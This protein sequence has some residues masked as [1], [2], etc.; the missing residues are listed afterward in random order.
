MR[1]DEKSQMYSLVE[2]TYVSF[3]THEPRV[4]K[5]APM[6]QSLLDQWPADQVLLVIAEDLELPTFIE[7]SGIRIVRS[8]DYGAF[9]KHGPLYMDLGIN[10][11]IVVDDDAVF[12]RGWFENLLFW[13]DRLP[14]HVVCG[15]GRIWKPAAVLHYPNS[16]TVFAG[17]ISEPVLC[18]IYNG[19][20]TAIFR[21][22]YFEPDVFPFPKRDFTYSEDIWISAKLKDNVSISVVPYSK[23]KH[24]ENIS[25][26]EALSYAWEK[27]SLCGQAMADGFANKNKALK[28]HQSKILA[29]A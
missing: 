20:D 2:D 1:I 17:E 21:R 9:K 14:G 3:T 15:R 8:K 13:S 19:V 26:P 22:D 6:L 27:S 16:E 5:I 12:P 10:Q 29:R 7:N 4:N 18:H 23:E 28:E 25:G 24:K 11:Y